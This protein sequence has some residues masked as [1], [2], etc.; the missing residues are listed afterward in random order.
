MK[1]AW[2]LSRSASRNVVL[3]L[4]VGLCVGCFFVSSGWGLWQNL[5]LKSHLLV[6]TLCVSSRLWV[7]GFSMS[8][9]YGHHGSQGYG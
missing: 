6:E 5:L 8:V 9:T 3:R 4:K 2:D 1:G 7:L